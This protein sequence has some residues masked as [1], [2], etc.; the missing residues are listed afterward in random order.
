MNVI[1]IRDKLLELWP[2]LKHIWPWDRQYGTLTK[3]QLDK[4][5]EQVRG[6]EIRFPDGKVVALNAMQNVGDVFDCDDFAAGGEFL[7]KLYHVLDAG[8]SALPIPY[9][10]AR[11]MQFRSMPGLHALNTAIVNDS[12]VYFIDH[13]DGGRTWSANKEADLLFYV[14]V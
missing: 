13:D 2:G 11:G 5:T 9:G 6:A 1:Q 4:Y 8:P 12:D 7:T 14:S 10:Q 3:A